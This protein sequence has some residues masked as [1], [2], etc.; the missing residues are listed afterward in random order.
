[1]FALLFVDVVLLEV[2]SYNTIV[3]VMNFSGKK[4]LPAVPLTKITQDNDVLLERILKMP[5]TTQGSSNNGTS[6]TLKTSV[7]GAILEVFGVSLLSLSL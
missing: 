4:P 3:E 1:M 7:S 6:T 2:E 5:I